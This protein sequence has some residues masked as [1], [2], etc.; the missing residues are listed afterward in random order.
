MFPRDTVTAMSVADLVKTIRERDGLSL[1][2]LGRALGVS[3][4]T[5]SHWQAGRRLP[6]ARH[7][8]Q[9]RDLAARDA[10]NPVAPE[11][12]VL[13]VHPI[14]DTAAMLAQMVRDVGA[15]LG[16]QL[17]VYHEA[18][19]MRALIQLGAL[20][21]AVMFVQYPMPAINVMQLIDGDGEVE[22]VMVGLY[23][24]LTESATATDSSLPVNLPNAASLTLP[25]SLG[26]I[27]QALRLSPLLRSDA[28]RLVVDA[29]R[30]YVR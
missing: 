25:V 11:N 22:G 12:R 19:S 6:Q 28:D 2:A 13:V 15:V 23:V 30:E 8:R 3:Y 9:L 4:V 27:G 17:Q 16:L 24:L 10:H 5:V 20:K 1:E 14:A 26:A 21:P 7:L 18:D 29:P